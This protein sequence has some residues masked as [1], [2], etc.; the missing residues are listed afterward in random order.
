MFVDADNLAET[1]TLRAGSDGR[2]EREKV[3]GGLFESDAVG[4]ETRGEIISDSCRENHQ[5]T[6][7]MSLVERGFCRVNKAR[8]GIL[9]SVDRETVNDEIEVCL[10]LADGRILSKKIIN[11][12]DIAT[13]S[14]T[15]VA[16]L[17]IDFEL[18]L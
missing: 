16:V 4:F 18:L 17:D 15:G 5:T 6:L 14:Q 10:L 3:V 7:A 13:I 1:L 12:D 8:D 2:I 9:S 11:A